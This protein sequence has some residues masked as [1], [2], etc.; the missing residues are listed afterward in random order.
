MDKRLTRQARFIFD[1]I[2]L[3][4]A[5]VWEEADVCDEL[6]DH[7]VILKPWVCSSGLW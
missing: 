1:E 2:I 3:P 5:Q 4:L 7:L 6:K